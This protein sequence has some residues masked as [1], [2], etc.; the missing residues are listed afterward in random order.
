MGLE[1]KSF[2]FG[3]KINGQNKKQRLINLFWITM[4][5]TMDDDFYFVLGVCYSSNRVA[6]DERGVS[7]LWPIG[8]RGSYVIDPLTKIG[9][10]FFFFP[11]KVSSK[12]DGQFN[13]NRRSFCLYIYYTMY[14][15]VPSSSP[16]SHFRLRFGL[17][18]QRVT[19]FTSNMCGFEV[20]PFFPYRL[21]QSPPSHDVYT[22][23]SSSM[24]I[25]QNLKNTTLYHYISCSL[26]LSDFVP[27]H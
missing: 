16:I 1:C 21:H 25:W 26:V 5:T 9:R 2:V 20:T 18:R 27:L 10:V 15:D 14:S 8:L 17:Q 13:R 12:S 24:Y 22:A 23:I 19:Y 11:H 6:T 7:S 3:W 4:T